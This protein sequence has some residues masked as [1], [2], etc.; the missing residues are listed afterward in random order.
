MIRDD[1][2]DQILDRTDIVEIISARVPLKKTGR[3]Y[4]APCP[5]HHEK[6]PSFIVSQD[7]KIFHCFGCGAGGNAISFLMKNDKL[8][9]REAVEILA[10]KAGIKLPTRSFT[11]SKEDAVFEKLRILNE[12][13]RDFYRSGLLSKDGAVAK[14][15]LSE[16]GISEESINLFHLGY[17]PQSWDGLIQYFHKKNTDPKTLIEAG[18]A[19]SRE[20]KEGHYDR[21]RNRV[22]FPIFDVN[23]KI[24]GFG[25]RALDD[26]LPKYINSPDSPV[27][28]KGRNLYGLNFSKNFIREKDFAIL[29]EGYLDLIIPYQYGIRNIVATL[30][31]ALTVDQIRLLKRYSKTVVIVYDS[32]K[33]GEEAALRGLDLLISYD[34]NVR[35]AAL[36]KGHDPD[37][38]VRKEGKDAFLGIIKSS[39]DLFDYKM[40]LLMSRYNKDGVRGRAAIA[41]LMLPTIARIPSEVLKSSFLMK[42]SETIGIDEAALRTEIRKVRS[43]YSRAVSIDEKLIAPPCRKARKAELLLLGLLIDEPQVLQVIEEN[44]GLESFNNS[45]VL[46]IIKTVK[47][48]SREEK[49]INPA[50]LISYFEDE[51]TKNVISESVGLLETVLDREKVLKDCVAR[52]KEDALKRE[53]D[54]LRGEIKSAQDLRDAMKIND[55]MTRYNDLLKTYKG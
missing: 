14:R 39:K 21:F 34:M 35:I 33:A 43:D 26:S 38:F 17:A 52:I 54:S 2:I 49:K 16:R 42:L 3:N 20:N 50:K 9:F 36:P 23:Q 10:E 37:T 5:F 27:F 47:E 25:A 46:V 1:V 53:L 30:G 40:R 28:S 55:L 18:L 22:I 8:S 44:L 11:G 12:G 13:A 7:K 19:L 4:K 31:T 24:I 29:V 15:Y 48:L 41:T 32:D 6:T 45:P 51:E